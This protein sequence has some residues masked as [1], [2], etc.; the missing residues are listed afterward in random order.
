MASEKY[1]IIKMVIGNEDA[2]L[3]CFLNLS[4][5]FI[6][7]PGLSPYCRAAISQSGA[8]V[9]REA[10]TLEVEGSNPSSGTNKFVRIGN[11]VVSSHSPT[12]VAATGI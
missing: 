3:P 9:A 1:D 11:S 2:F 6:C 7:P 4:Y 12:S 8:A 10:H 5:S